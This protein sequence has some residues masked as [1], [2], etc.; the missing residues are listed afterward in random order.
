M[1]IEWLSV[2]YITVRFYALIDS[3]NQSVSSPVV[4]KFSISSSPS[5]FWSPTASG[6][7]PT[8]I[9]DRS[10]K[11][12]SDTESAIMCDASPAR[13][14]GGLVMAVLLLLVTALRLS[15]P[16]TRAELTRSFCSMQ[17]SY[18]PLVW[19]DPM[20]AC[21]VLDPDS[22]CHPSSSI[23]A[24]DD[25]PY[26]V[27]EVRLKVHVI[28]T[29]ALI[30]LLCSIIVLMRALLVLLLRAEFQPMEASSCTPP[31]LLYPATGACPCRCC[32]SS[33]QRCIER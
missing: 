31:R 22:R 16:S 18:C 32:L 12:A 10:I 2:L 27:P 4:S 28:A 30:Q 15:E 21:N 17:P 23:A 7:H 26:T 13:R 20:E 1:N 24:I 19:R 3:N 9:A 11:K 33:W 8:K 5:P 29:L 6:T 14:R 25:T